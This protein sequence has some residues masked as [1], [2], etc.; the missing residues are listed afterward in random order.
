MTFR[1]G[2]ARAPSVFAGAGG[3]S[4][5]F[6]DTGS[7]TPQFYIGDPQANTGITYA[8]QTGNYTRLGNMCYAT[9][10]MALTS[11]G[12]LNGKMSINLPFACVS[13]EGAGGFATGWFNFVNTMEFI[14]IRYNSSFGSPSLYFA[15]ASAAGSTLNFDM[16]N[17]QL[18][19]SSGMGFKIQY[20]YA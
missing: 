20:R 9:G 12:S 16:D 1:A 18:S 8:S 10:Y 6:Y 17:F 14:L 13:N 5:P 2:Q 4:I 3:A 11:I 15:M 7:W 19:N